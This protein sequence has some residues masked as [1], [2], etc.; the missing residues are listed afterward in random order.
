MKMI[1]LLDISSL[2]EPCQPQTCS[3]ISRQ[4]LLP[5]GYQIYHAFKDP[6]DKSAMLVCYTGESGE[7]LFLSYTIR[8][9]N[10]MLSFLLYPCDGK[11]EDLIYV[12]GKCRMMFPLLTTG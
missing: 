4:C 10:Q 8:C 2:V 5:Y 6:T 1:G 7:R 11:H 12:S 9:I 3:F